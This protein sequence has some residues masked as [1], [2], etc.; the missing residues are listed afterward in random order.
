MLYAFKQ[1]YRAAFAEIRARFSCLYIERDQPRVE[2]AEE[3]AARTGAVR[4]RAAPVSR[5]AIDHH[6]AEAPAFV[7]F[8]IE[9]P[10]FRPGFGI[11]RNGAV[12]RRGEDQA[13]F[14]QDRRCFKRSASKRLVR[15]ARFAHIAV[16]VS[17]GDFESLH[18]IAVD[19]D[20]RRVAPASRA[21]FGES[22]SYSLF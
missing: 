15:P 16:S 22:P 4:V 6:V 5:A 11:E 18:V 19:V 9:G 20:E 8:R 17:P 14:D 1:I 2:R 10:E 21:A 3:D 12:E 7:Y 13:A